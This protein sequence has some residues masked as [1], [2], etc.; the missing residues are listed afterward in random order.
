M[1]DF[2]ASVIPADV[3]WQPS[4][5]AAAQA[6]EY[7]RHAFPDPDG[8]AQSIQV[9]F[10]DRITAV[11]AAENLL[12]ITCPGCGA[13]IALDWYH[14]LLEEAEGEFDTLAVTVPCCDALLG[15]D[16]LLF[17]WPCGFARFE[18]AVANPSRPEGAFSA[19]ELDAIAAILGHPVRQILAHI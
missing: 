3:L 8:M 1:S 12:R 2:Y 18:I 5:E 6:E 9:S 16:T 14:D 4:H 19:A 15:L 7:V 11:D 10:Y 17:E 13:R